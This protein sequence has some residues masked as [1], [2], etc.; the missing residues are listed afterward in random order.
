MPKVSIVMAVYNTAEAYFR[1]A[2]ESALAQTFTDFEF[3]IIDDCSKPYIEK[4]VKSYDDKRIKY[5]KLSVNSGQSVARNKGIDSAKGTYI[6]LFDSD[7]VWLPTKLEKQVRFLDEHPEIGCIG[8]KIDVIGNDAWEGDYYAGYESPEKV[9]FGLVCVGCVLFISTVMIR[10]SVLDKYHVRYQTKF[11][12]SEDYA[13]YVDLIGKTKFQVLPEVMA[14]YRYYFDNTSHRFKQ[15]QL[16][17]YLIAKREAILQYFKPKPQEKELLVNF[18]SGRGLKPKEVE[19]LEDFIPKIQKVFAAHG[20]SDEQTRKLM[21][22]K[23]KNIY[24][25]T[26]S[27]KA[28][29]GL[30]F[31]PF[32]REHGLSFLWRLGCFITR[33]LFK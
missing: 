17:K 20:L 15:K 11:V 29:A 24:Y 5:Q 10:K 21:K 26:H 2:I 4:I 23:I 13:L 28:Q 1:E 22:K 8:S 31:K 12:P 27:L 25:H 7:D 33:G 30:L 6:A 19:K 3:W 18:L 32:G 14:K 16:E 9:E